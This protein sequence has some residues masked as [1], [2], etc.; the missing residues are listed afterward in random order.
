MANKQPLPL[1]DLRSY[2]SLSQSDIKKLLDEEIS[3]FS[4]PWKA[5]II[6]CVHAV[7]DRDVNVT[8]S[9]FGRNPT[10]F[11]ICD[12]LDGN[13]YL[14][15]QL[16]F[17]PHTYP[18]PRNTKLMIDTTFAIPHS[19]WLDLKRDICKSTHKAAHPI[20]SNGEGIYH[21]SCCAESRN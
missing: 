17:Y 14:T 12:Y 8:P 4:K 9:F 11:D 20:C 2:S 7:Q 21:H 3:V 10:F 19:R 6:F 15:N 13:N 18:S 1:K 16:Y 5:S